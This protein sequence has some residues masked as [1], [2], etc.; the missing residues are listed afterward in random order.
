MYSFNS[1]P[2]TPLSSDD[3]DDN[4][5]N[6]GFQRGPAFVAFEPGIQRRSLAPS[7]SMSPMPSSSHRPTRSNP[8]SGPTATPVRQGPVPAPTPQSGDGYQQDS[9]L[10]YTDAPSVFP[11]L[12][13]P[14]L[15]A[16]DQQGHQGSGPAV[17]PQGQQAPHNSFSQPAPN[18]APTPPWNQN[19]SQWIPRAVPDNYTRQGTWAAPPNTP[20]N[21]RPAV[22]GQYQNPSPYTHY[23]QDTQQRPQT[24]EPPAVLWN[25]NNQQNQ[26]PA[27]NP[28][29]VNQQIPTTQPVVQ[30]VAPLPAVQPSIDVTV[31]TTPATDT[32]TP[33]NATTNITPEQPPID[34]LAAKLDEIL[35][36]IS[37][38]EAPKPP[39]RPPTPDRRTDAQAIA[40]NQLL[41]RLAG[42]EG[43]TS[44]LQ[45]QLS[46][47][48]SS[49]SLAKIKCEEP[50][51]YD[52]NPDKLETFL[53]QLE[54]I[55]ASA[56]SRYR[57]HNIRIRYTFSRMRKDHAQTWTNIKQPQFMKGEIV[58]DSWDD[59]V[60]E[61]QATFPTE[62]K[63]L[64][65]ISM[66][67]TLR[68]DPNKHASDF[69]IQWEKWAPYTGMNDAGLLVFL[70][71][72]I[73]PGLRR[74][75]SH[76][77]DLSSLDTCAKFKDAA[78][79]VDKN[80]RYN[81]QITA[82]AQAST[83]NT[84]VRPFT[85]KAAYSK[86]SE[87]QTPSANA[88][89]TAKPQAA[90][91]PTEAKVLK[92]GCFNCGSLEHKIAACPIPHKK[93]KHIV[94]SCVLGMT[95][96]EVEALSQDLQDDKFYDPDQVFYPD[97]E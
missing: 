22:W 76:R 19:G 30:P 40:Y 66:V 16:T 20:Y 41:D 87:S 63:R 64:K 5:G 59:F 26:R 13:N 53:N 68:M 49:E 35:R 67:E 17:Y 24:N 27:G 91:L 89:S 12:N 82:Q 18:Y 34:P 86:P 21:I 42:L 6:A 11:T 37:V 4:P 70:L 51:Q 50:D 62:D 84:H 48:S 29:P 96:E 92:S 80:W 28:T 83:S 61:L 94:R 88:T 14:E 47:K 95:V 93:P 15:P 38:L 36:R 69:F 31:N 65:A 25:L 78:V 72:A 10:S 7:L 2:L 39:A 9:D 56:P 43:A 33:G 97:S 52:G 75:I 79:T 45:Y 85:K 23:G 32:T 74:E 44:V 77:H 8:Y 90:P 71:K 54:L 73:S 3:S 60:L 46:K 81:Q 58:W 55:W 1:S 57:D